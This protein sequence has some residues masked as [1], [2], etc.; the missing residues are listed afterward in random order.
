MPA[1]NIPA[2]EPDPLPPSLQAEID[3]SVRHFEEEL[4]GMFVLAKM[5]GWLSKYRDEITARVRSAYLA[6]KAEVR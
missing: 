3:T 4:G 6:G 5:N 2:P 1:F